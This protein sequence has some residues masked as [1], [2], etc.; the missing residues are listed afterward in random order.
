MRT[1][2]MICLVLFVAAALLVLL[3]LWLT[4]FSAELFTKLLITLGVLFVVALGI[5]LVRREFAEEKKM[6]DGGY[7]D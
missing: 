7:I 2:A 4:P 5:A 3:Q 6:K 1:G